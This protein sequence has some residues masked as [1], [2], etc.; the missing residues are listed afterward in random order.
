MNVRLWLAI[1]I[2]GENKPWKLWR[3]S[4]SRN[5]TVNFVSASN[6]LRRNG[7]RLFW[8]IIISVMKFRR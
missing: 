1:R 4:A 7:M 6:S 3:L 5:R 8:L 2:K